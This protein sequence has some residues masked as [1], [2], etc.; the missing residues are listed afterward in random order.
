MTLQLTIKMCFSDKSNN[1]LKQLLSG[2]EREK[3]KVQISGCHLYSLK[4]T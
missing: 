1:V 3:L 2:R 4:A